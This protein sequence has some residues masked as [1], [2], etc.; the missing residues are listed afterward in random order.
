MTYKKADGGG[1]I[2][3]V[4]L[5]VGVLSTYFLLMPGLELLPFHGWV[6][7]NLTHVQQDS[8]SV[9]SPSSHM[10]TRRGTFSL[11]A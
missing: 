3:A 11:P 5:A 10:S 9:H 8:A 7:L 2:S 4:V 1:V 6:N